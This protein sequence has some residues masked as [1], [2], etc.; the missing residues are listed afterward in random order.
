MEFGELPFFL[1]QF[2][3]KIICSFYL[4]FPLKIYLLSVLMIHIFFFL[5]IQLEAEKNKLEN[6]LNNNL[7]RR[8]DELEA[9]CVLLYLLNQIFSFVCDSS[10]SLIL[11]Y[12]YIYRLF[13]KFQ[14]KT[15]GGNQTIVMLNWVPLTTESTMSIKMSKVRSSFYFWFYLAILKVLQ[16]SML[17][18]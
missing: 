13:K 12:F 3:N 1:L 8:K 15:E 16:I 10:E 18:K 6:L 11:I 14:W 2:V 7:Y 17:D 9:V 5:F 4:K